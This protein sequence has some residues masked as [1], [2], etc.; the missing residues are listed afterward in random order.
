MKKENILTILIVVFIVVG[1]IWY[2]ESRNISNKSVVSDNGYD[3]GITDGVKEQF[4]EEKNIYPDLPATPLTVE[5]CE[6]YLQEYTCKEGDNLPL[7]EGRKDC[8]PT[9]TRNLGR[10]M[11]FLDGKPDPYGGNYGH[12]EELVNNNEEAQETTTIINVPIFGAHGNIELAAVEI[13]YTQAVL[14]ETLKKTFEMQSDER[15]YNGLYFDSVSLENGLAKINMTGSWY[16]TGDLSGIYMRN[17]IKAAV[18][19]F[20]TV[21]ALHVYVNNELFDWCI[22]SQADVS[23]SHCDTTPKYWI[24]TK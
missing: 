10:C 14:K 19:Q 11:S 7:I 6:K 16:P 4:K 15:G 1:G 20:D 24:D 18:L 2:I 9:Y 8:N 22:D 12:T 13:P 5:A 3:F 23:E 21:S 17:A